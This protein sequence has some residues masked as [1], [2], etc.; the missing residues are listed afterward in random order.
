NPALVRSTRL[1]PAHTRV[2]RM[3]REHE[4]FTPHHPLVPL[5][6][7]SAGKWRIGHHIKPADPILGTDFEEGGM[8]RIH[9]HLQ[10]SM[11]IDAHW[12]RDLF[13]EGDKV[14]WGEPASGKGHIHH[15]LLLGPAHP[16]CYWM[17]G[18]RLAYL[19]SP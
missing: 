2:V 6:A 3:G 9:G 19:C 17:S 4:G 8:G 15:V 14:C 5:S 18:C 13:K 7:P 12:Y 1:V 16:V 11:I 10:P